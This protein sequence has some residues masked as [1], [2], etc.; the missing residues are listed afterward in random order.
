M[1]RRKFVRTAAGLLVP[2]ALARGAVPL[3]LGFW[4]PSSSAAV[5]NP[6][7]P[8]TLPNLGSWWKAD[9]VTGLTSLDP[10]SAWNDSNLSNHLTGSGASRPLWV[11]NVFGTKPAVRFDGTDDF[12]S[13]DSTLTLNV[14]T[15][16]TIVVVMA[17][18]DLIAPGANMLFSSPTIGNQIYFTNGNALVFL[19]G[20][21]S[22]GFGLSPMATPS[23][24]PRTV[25]FKMT[26]AGTTF[27]LRENT[28]LV[29]SQVQ[30]HGSNLIFNTMG[31]SNSGTLYLKADVSEI[32][33]YDG[34]LSDAN[35]DALFV[36]YLDVKY[37]FPL[38]T[39][40]ASPAL[41]T[42]TQ[43]V[44]LSTKLGTAIRY[45]TDGTEPSGASSLYTGALSIT[46]DPTCLKSLATRSGR[47]NS[48]VAPNLY[49]ALPPNTIHYWQLWNLSGIIVPDLVGAADITNLGGVLTPLGLT[50]NGSSTYANTPA[51][52]VGSND[53]SIIVWAKYPS[54]PVTGMMVNKGLVNANYM[55]F[56]EGSALV[57]RSGAGSPVTATAP[58]ANV[59]H[60]IVG[61]VSTGILGRIY[62]DGSLVAGPGAITAITDASNAL[63]I[64]SYNCCGYYFPGTIGLI[65]VCTGT[66]SAA[67]VTAA[68]TAQRKI[69]GV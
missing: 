25:V 45:T 61:T 53:I 14:S 57:L 48:G 15:K 35:C 7:Y 44:T 24:V 12:L 2:A 36:N 64:G 42:P 29:Q 54:I 13:M 52:L 1:N 39:P 34:E 38:D 51:F 16:F 60:Q 11:A 63:T 62:V 68:W 21:T 59:W 56:F 47:S 18:T 66:L 26:V 6:N 3:P 20:N 43:T 28:A 37:Q 30:T 27:A 32:I 5:Y 67:D 31:K 17:W 8:T 46:T 10:L 50:F 69:F 41:G 4:K 9:S 40:I 55:L 22:T 19:D 33:I 58:T 49:A 23:N 65:Q